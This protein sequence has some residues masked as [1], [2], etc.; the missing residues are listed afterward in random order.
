[1]TNEEEVEKLVSKLVDKYGRIEILVNMVG[2]FIGGKT[3][4]EIEE[5]EWDMMMN[6]NL[7]SAFFIRHNFVVRNAKLLLIFGF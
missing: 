2:A 6:I 7:K 1:M 3:V 4:M 5:K